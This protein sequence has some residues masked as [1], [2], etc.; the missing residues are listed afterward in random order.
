MKYSL[1]CVTGYDEEFIARSDNHAKGYATKRLSVARG[2]LWLYRYKGDES[3]ALAE[4]IG[5]RNCVYDEK[6]QKQ[7]FTRWIND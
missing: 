6:K 7:I 4:L 2:S 3:F 5:K 1:H